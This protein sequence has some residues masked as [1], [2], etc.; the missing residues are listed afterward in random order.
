MSNLGE[1]IKKLG[2]GLMRLPMKDEKIDVEQTKVMVDKF[3]DAGFTY[4][5]TAWAYAGSEDA[6]RQALV[7]RYPRESYQL[8]TKNAAWIN[9][10]TREEAIA[11]FET[12]LKQTGAGYFDFYLLHNLG[13]SRTQF[14]D[15]FDMWSF[16][17][18]KKA[19]GLI[20][21]I[22]FSF[23]STPEELEEILKSHPEME[24]VQLQINYADWENP[25]IQSKACYEM[26]RKYGKEVVI[27]EPVKGGMLATPPESVAN[28][29]KQANPD[30]SVASWAIKFVANLDGVITVLSGMSNVEQMEDNLSYMKDFKGLSEEEMKVIEK[31]QEELSKIDIIPCTVCNYCA[32][33]CPNEIGISGSFTALNQLILYGNKAAAQHQEGWLVGGHG[34]KQ[35]SECLQ[36]GECEAVCPQH[37]HI[38]EQLERVTEE[39]LDK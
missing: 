39:L 7:E 11:Q 35:A 30:V 34:R 29:F 14:F 22:G 18:E 36:C 20:K 4:F 33:V 37:I 10:N 5:D 15:K 9:C 12:S 1:N 38:I 28:L 23:H 13:E 17:Q 16:V 25:A 21:H 31:A 2:F 19:E 27:M 6:I 26:A 8:A 32:K 24:F 3:L